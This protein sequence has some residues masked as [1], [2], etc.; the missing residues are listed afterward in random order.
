MNDDYDE[1]EDNSDWA[2]SDNNDDEPI[3]IVQ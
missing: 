3:N 2:V 1:K